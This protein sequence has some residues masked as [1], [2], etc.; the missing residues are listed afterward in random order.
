VVWRP[1]VHC[2][3]WPDRLVD[4]QQAQIDIGFDRLFSQAP[5]IGFP[6]KSFRIV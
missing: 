2:R 6:R 1:L 4:L 5:A 3:L